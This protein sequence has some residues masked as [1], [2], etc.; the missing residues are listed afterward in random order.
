MPTI[1]LEIIT[2]ER[3]VFSDDVDTVV[4]P[5]S[6]GQL[7]ILPRHAPLMTALQPGEIMIRKN[8]EASYLAVTGGFM[9]V[10]GDRVTIL[11]DA[12]ER[13][14]EIDES[15]AQAAV[16][17]ARQQI[18]RRESNLQLQEAAVAM[19]RAQARLTVARRRRARPGMGPGPSAEG[20]AAH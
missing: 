17:L 3:Q 9:E 20:G 1:H 5:G 8:G 7:G 14:D 16:E 13:S 6:E 11:A 2:A 10:M 4:A 15:R 18:S 12:C 19:R